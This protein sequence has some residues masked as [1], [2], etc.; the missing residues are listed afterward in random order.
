[1]FGL[2]G[3]PKDIS[4]ADLSATTCMLLAIAMGTGIRT[5]TRTGTVETN[6]PS[7]FHHFVLK[8]PLCFFVFVIVLIVYLIGQVRRTERLRNFGANSG[9]GEEGEYDDV[10]WW[11]ENR[12]A[13]FEGCRYRCNQRES[14]SMQYNPSQP[15]QLQSNPIALDLTYLTPTQPK[16][17]GHSTS[18]TPPPSTRP[19][20]PPS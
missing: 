14:L 13:A 2:D 8:Y 5:R 12:V 17:W 16:K 20:P 9:G 6:T 4:D 7:F 15:T 3:G 11:F 10:V 18:P 19:P 1:M